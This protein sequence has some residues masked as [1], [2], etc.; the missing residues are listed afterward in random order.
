MCV[1]CYMRFVNLLHTWAT[2]HLISIQAE[3]HHVQ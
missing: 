1:F 2:R 3:G